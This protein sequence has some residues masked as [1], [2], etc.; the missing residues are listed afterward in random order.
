[1]TPEEGNKPK[2][3]ETINV[4]DE[5]FKLAKK[6][7][8]SD[9]TITAGKSE[10]KEVIRLYGEPETIDE[11][12]VGRFAVFPNHQMTIGFQHS[13]AFDLRSFGNELQE[14]YYKDILDELG[15][16]DEIKYYQ[17]TENNQII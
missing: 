11:T 12:S 13:I 8:I 5:I 7:E 4:V 1:V 10:Y 6:G 16:P 15:E 2:E 9:A 3:P 14:V 17:D